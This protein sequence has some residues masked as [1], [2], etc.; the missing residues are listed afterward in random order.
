MIDALDRSLEAFLR[1]AVP[2]P[3]SQIDVMFGAPDRDW[4]AQRNRPTVGLFLYSI[5]PA[6]TRAASGLRER[7]VGGDLVRE[8][9]LP[10]MALTYVVTAWVSD[11]ADEHR[12]LGDLMRTIASNSELPVQ[13][14]DAALPFP[15]ERLAM[16]LVG[17]KDRPRFD[18]WGPLGVSPRVSLDLTVYLPAGPPV[19][20]DTAEPPTTVDID[21]ADTE[22]AS[23]ASRRRRL[24]GRT[25]PAHAGRRVVGRRGSATVEESGHYTL[26]GDSVDELRLVSDTDPDGEELTPYPEGADGERPDHG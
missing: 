21:L 16:S 3:A 10:T 19:S 22:R 15:T 11:P 5:I 6:T 23:R 13:D 8:R 4:S 1:R 18:G 17:E 24:A 12:L 2:L 26:P 7:R 14:R 25:D 20:M 9:E